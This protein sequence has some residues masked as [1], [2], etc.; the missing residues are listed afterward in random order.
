AVYANDEV[1]GAIEVIFYVINHAGERIGQESD[2]SIIGSYLDE[3]YVVVTVDYKNSHY[4][5][6]PYLEHSLV[7]VRTYYKSGNGFSGTP[8]SMY[9]YCGYFLPAGYRIA[10]DITFWESDKHGSKGTLDAVIS[11]WNIDIY[12]KGKKMADGTPAKEAKT[13]EDCTKKDGSAMDYT[14]ELDIIYPSQP[15][16][17]TPIYAMAATQDRKH[18]HTADHTSC[19]Y[20]GFTFNGYTAVVWDHEYIPMARSDH[21]GYIDHYGTQS[22]N[23]NKVAT[24]AVRCIRYFEDTYGYNADLIGVGGISKGSYPPAFLSRD[25][26]HLI[27]ERK[28]YAQSENGTRFE[29]DKLDANGNVIETIRQPYLTYEGG[30][31]STI[32]EEEGGTPI[33]THITVAYS[34]AGDGADSL[35]QVHK[36][37]TGTPMVLSCGID[38]PYGCW[39]RWAPLVKHFQNNY[40]KPFIHMGM[41]DRDMFTQQVMM[42]TK[43]TKDI[44]SL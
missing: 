32:T 30:Y 26:N 11:A 22:Y 20:L 39:N 5:V 24:A 1:S 17:A 2:E 36:N 18:W 3:G 21:W 23:G 42:L 29:G 27:P 38:D 25:N 14:L 34:A 44:H 33:P 4:A 6:T 16:Y 7:D 8:Y 37:Y 28:V 15:K 10:K 12:G 35:Y 19:N 41:L 9:E 43:N 31:E 13:I 40:T